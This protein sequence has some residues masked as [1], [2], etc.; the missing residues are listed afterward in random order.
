VRFVL[1]YDG[2]L[3]AN[4]SPSAKN[5]VRLE[6]TPQLQQLWQYEHSLSNLRQVHPQIRGAHGEHNFVPIVT[7]EHSL[8]CQLEITLLQPGEP[9]TVLHHGGGDLDNRLKTLFDSLGVP[10]QDQLAGLPPVTQAFLDHAVPMPN[11]YVL[12]EDDSRITRLDVRIERFLKA[13]NP[14][15]VHVFVAVT[16]RPTQVTEVNKVFSAAG[17]RKRAD[18]HQA[19]HS[20]SGR[21]VGRGLAS[22][23]SALKGPVHRL[24]HGLS[25]GRNR[26]RVHVERDTR[27][28]VSKLLRDRDEWRARCWLDRGAAV[29]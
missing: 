10:N 28:A 5:H 18:L 9:G 29:A 1:L 19:C 7:A 8:V 25:H 6:L 3:P 23:S 24:G 4:G 12:L 11:I 14:H 21:V 17:F 26:M 20:H 15:D 13:G 2:P 22:S 16:I 27:L